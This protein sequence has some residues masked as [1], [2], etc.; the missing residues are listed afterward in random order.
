MPDFAS[1]SPPLPDFNPAGLVEVLLTTSLDGI[2]LLRPRYAPEGPEIIDFDWVRLNPAAQQMLNLPEHPTESFLTLYPTANSIGVFDFYREAFESGRLRQRQNLYQ[3]DG[4]DGYYVLRAQRHENVLVVSFTDGNDQERTTIEETLRASQARE[5]EARAEAERQRNQWQALVNQAPVA[6]GLFEG[7]ELRITA[8]NTRLADMW[9]RPQAELLDRPLLEAVPELRGQGFEHLMEQVRDT[10]VPYVGTEV[11]A[12]LL[13]NGE[14]T[15]TYYNFVYQP[16]YDARGEVL[17]VLDVALEVT[18]QVLARRQVEELNQDLEAQVLERTQALR[19]AYAAAEQQREQLYQVFEQTPVAIAILRGPN[20]RVELANPA[21]LAIWGREVSQ[22]MGRP[23]LEALPETDGPGFGQVLSGVLATGQASFLVDAPVTLTRTHTGQA[24]QAYVSFAFQPLFDANGEIN[25][26]MASGTEVTEQVLVRQQVQ[27]LNRELQAS[28]EALEARVEIRTREAQ[29]AQMAAER[30]QGELERVLEQAPVAIAVYRGPQYIIELANPTVCRL[31]GRNQQDIIGKGLFEALPEVAGMGYEELLDGVMATGEPYV[32]HAMPAQ[33]DRNGRRETVYWD[34]VYVP[35]YE[36][37]G[38]IY[39]AMVV[40]TEVT[41]Q[42]LAR[43]QVQQLNDQLEVRVQERTAQAHAALREAQDQREQ[44]R[45]Q[46]NLLSQIL[47]QVPAAVATLSGPDHRFTFFNDQYYALSGNRARLG[48]T[49]AEALPEIVE[50]GFLPLLN[51]VYTS[52]EPFIGKEIAVLL[53]QPTGPA[54]QQYLDFTYQPLTD[55]Q[56][57]VYGILV[58]ALDVTEQVRTRRQAETLQAAALAAV[59]RRAQQRQELYQIFAQ[60]PVAIVLLREPDHRIDYFNPAFEELFPPEEWTGTDMHGHTLAEVYPRIK[61][62]GLITLLDVVFETGEPQ[63]VLDMPLAN[64]HPGSPRYVTFSY[65]AYRE[66]GRIVG[67]A[68]FIYDVTDQVRARQQ[69]QFLN[70]E[71]A[72]ING[73]M[74]A[75]NEE[76]HLTNARLTRTNT[77]L[78]TFVYT[79][80][81]DLKAPIANIEGLLLALRQDLPAHVRQGPVVARLLDLIQDSVTR[82]Q[83]TIGHLTDISQLQQTEA[84]ETMDLAAL[85]AGVQ[86]DLAPLIEAAG[87]TLSIDLAGCEAIHVAPKTLRSVV[88]NL[89]SNAVKYRTPDRPAQVWLRARCTPERLTVTVQDNGLGL[90]EAQ[91][92]DLFGMFRRLHT[93]VEGSGVGLFTVKRLVEN[94]GGTIIVESQAGQGSTF[95]VSLPA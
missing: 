74:Q 33:H 1:V 79:A 17:G 31:W 38:R 89:L 54:S 91:Q 20:L 26:V 22:V 35:M 6:L 53:A 51:Q 78:D 11:P 84:P 27:Q 92:I 43:Q 15:T 16:L 67:V 36:D 40:A 80:S 14:L 10:R 4:L 86:L 48:Q 61:T 44:L 87:A 52:G 77:D 69:V 68:A 23:Y 62:A 18:E 12:R 5:R 81:H 83:R 82:F 93:H 64:L 56:G 85:I 7:P 13:R 42:V 34:F 24:N 95:T 8:A 29:R 88:Y 45:E 76:L 71:L 55:R 28:N 49:V 73:E 63:A 59:Q 57:Q 66:Q 32:A 90:T 30:Q 70:E 50:Q 41:E 39:G 21:I 58:F 94:A 19:H 9:G 60:T 46:Q 37:D 3:H 72:T 65:Q 75:T 25:G 2:L 47:A